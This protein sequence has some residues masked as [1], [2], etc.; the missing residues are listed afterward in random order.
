F[1]EAY[2]DPSG[3][4]VNRAGVRVNN[5][6]QVVDLN[7]RIIDPRLYA[8]GIVLANQD[9]IRQ[10]SGAGIALATA[11]KAVQSS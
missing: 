2:F 10:R 8:S 9:W 4:A 6:F 11:Y 1:Q 5:N 3:H 7:Q